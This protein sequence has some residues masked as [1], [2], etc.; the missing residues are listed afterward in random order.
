MALGDV[1][2]EPAPITQDGAVETRR[3][4]SVKTDDVENQ[5]SRRPSRIDKKDEFSDTESNLSVGAQIELE[6]HNAIQ[7]RTCGWKKVRHCSIQNDDPNT[8]LD[9]ISSVFGIHLSRYH[10]FPIQASN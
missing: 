6:K 10:V 9:F 4:S 7:Y 3:Q 1:G 5:G 8:L 2:A